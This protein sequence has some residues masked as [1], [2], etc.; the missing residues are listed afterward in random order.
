MSH[1]RTH[2]NVVQRLITLYLEITNFLNN[3][4]YSAASQ[5]KQSESYL[6]DIE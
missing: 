1:D 3:S 2:F 5:A 4:I 6:I